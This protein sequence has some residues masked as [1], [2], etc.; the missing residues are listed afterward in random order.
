VDAWQRNEAGPIEALFT[1][2]A[3]YRFAPF[4]EDSVAHGRAEIVK[5]WLDNPDPP[6]T[7]EASYEPFAVDGN[8]AVATGTSHYL[9]S[10]PRGDRTYYNVYLVEF[11][12][13]GRCSSFTELYMREPEP[14]PQP[15]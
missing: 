1:E 13:D 11:A 4:G 12:P 14:A 5:A 6:G 8:R 10:H 9:P 3:T 15:D 2:E 7:W